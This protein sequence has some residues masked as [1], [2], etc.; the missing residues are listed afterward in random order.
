MRSQE[1]HSTDMLELELDLLRQKVMGSQTSLD[2]DD[3]NG[4]R[5]DSYKVFSSMKCDQIYVTKG[6]ASQNDFFYY[7]VK[8]ILK[9]INQKNAAFAGTL[10]DESYLVKK[11]GEKV[12]YVVESERLKNPTLSILHMLKEADIVLTDENANFDN[13]MKR[14]KYE[15]TREA[16]KN[17]YKDVNRWE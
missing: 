16:N 14:L 2:Q 10:V 6:G 12:I 3:A 13:I 1:I 7:K 5:K 15:V 8:T 11:E 9:N 4:Q 17:E